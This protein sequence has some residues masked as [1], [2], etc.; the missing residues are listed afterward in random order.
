MR[1]VK[2]RIKKIEDTVNCT[3][4]YIPQY[5]KFLLWKNMHL[6]FSL[7]EAKQAIKTHRIKSA[8]KELNK[9]CGTKDKIVTY[10]NVKFE[11]KKNE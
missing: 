3:E 8:K 11:K 9:I 7:D 2:Y 4:R 6:Y 10:L 5:K 1:D